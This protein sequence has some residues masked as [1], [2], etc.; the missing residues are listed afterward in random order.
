M[1]TTSA[2]ATLLSLTAHAS[3]IALTPRDY[4]GIA[5]NLHQDT[6]CA[7]YAQETCAIPP[8]ATAN[9]TDGPDKYQSSKLVSA[10]GCTPDALLEIICNS[11]PTARALANPSPL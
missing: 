4:K 7:D 10:D 8:C 6:N 5:L 1:I 3:V 9:S 2:Y 11:D